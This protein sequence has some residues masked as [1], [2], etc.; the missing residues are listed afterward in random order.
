MERVVSNALLN[1]KPRRA[2]FGIR[3]L[4]NPRFLRLEKGIFDDI[5]YYDIVLIHEPYPVAAFD[6]FRVRPR[7][8]G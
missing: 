2:K 5:E 3:F 6:D 1:Q 4:L 7:N 8:H